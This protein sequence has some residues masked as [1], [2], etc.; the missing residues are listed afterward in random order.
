LRQ[1]KWQI[2]ACKTYFETLKTERLLKDPIEKA[3]L[4]EITHAKNL[5]NTKQC[6]T[7][8][9]PGYPSQV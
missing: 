1:G 9:V 3:K 2:N 6:V 7:M 4:G 5:N 8:L